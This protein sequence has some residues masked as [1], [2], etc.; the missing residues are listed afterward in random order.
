MTV[1]PS[2]SEIQNNNLLIPKSSDKET[3]APSS[4][5][6]TFVF[7]VGNNMMQN[8]LL[9]SF[10]KGETNIEGACIQNLNPGLLKSK[11]KATPS[12]F[13]I[14]DCKSVDMD[15]FWNNLD[16]WRNEMSCPCYATLYNVEAHHGIVKTALLRHL[17]GVFLKDEP[18]SLI[19][20]G[21]TTILSGRMWYKRS[22][23]EKMLLELT[24][25][26]DLIDNE[27]AIDLTPREKE[28]LTLI[29]SGNNNTRIAQELYISIHTVKTHIYNIFK[30][31]NVKNRFQAVLWAAN[32]L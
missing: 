18:L 4:E 31:I 5:K 14:V 9:L 28:I 22:A 11:E 8:E 20:K 6:A 25:F 32:H 1:L 12:Q 13:L 23:L 30:K 10:V 27:V 7:V 21:I 19:P 16:I 24:V 15:N 2:T 3:P 26:N 29:S 17:H